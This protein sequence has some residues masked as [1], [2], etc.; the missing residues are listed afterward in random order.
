[1]MLIWLGIILAVAVLILLI[2]SAVIFHVIFS[3]IGN[4]H[5]V[6]G[7]A[8]NRIAAP[9]NAEEMK[10]QG[11]D[12]FAAHLQR[13]ARLNDAGLRLAAFEY[14]NPQTTA[15][16]VIVQHGYRE[17]HRDVLDRAVAFAD[18]GFNVLL[19]DAQ[20]HGES[21]G[22]FVQMGYRDADDLLTWIS[23][24]SQRPDVRITVYGTSMGGSAVLFLAGKKLP[25][26]VQA[27]VADSAYASV[28]AEIDYQ[29]H[30]FL[31]GRILPEMVLQVLG[32]FVYVRLGWSL[33]NASALPG[34]TAGSTPLLLLHG[35][36]DTFV[37]PAMMTAAYASA[38]ATRKKQ[39][40]IPTAEHG[41]GCYVLGNAYWELVTDFARKGGATGDA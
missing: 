35:S 10:R 24:L 13:V 32:I 20:A 29:L 19:P 1:M 8:H 41:M 3:R 6:F 5:L 39:V 2:I 36:A 4:R 26:N 17:T 21:A 38:A 28:P 23:Y 12:E 40:L 15:D 18:R 16:W 34:L 37:P 30:Q 7:A 25:K 11:V 9:T 22:Q 14:V 33:R 27:L 31:P